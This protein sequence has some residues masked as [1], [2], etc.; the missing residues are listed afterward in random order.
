MRRRSLN[1]HWSLGLGI[2][3]LM[4]SGNVA[5]ET[6][7]WSLASYT[8]GGPFLEDVKQ[9]AKNVEFLTEGR[10]KIE[11]FPGGTLGHPFK[12]V[13]LWLPSKVLGGF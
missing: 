8:A 13:A 9:L 12:D 3:A 7:T 1:R 11:V 4:A 10:L 6:T 2:A 5:A